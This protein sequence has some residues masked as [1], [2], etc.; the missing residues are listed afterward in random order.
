MQKQ[1]VLIHDG[2]N[3]GKSKKELGA[4]M[5]GGQVTTSWL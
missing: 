3:V 5:D 1:F 4:N 2:G